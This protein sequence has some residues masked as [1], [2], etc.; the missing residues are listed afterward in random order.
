MLPL[1]RLSESCLYGP[2]FNPLPVTVIVRYR[3]KQG[4]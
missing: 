1:L 4:G 3:K 2:E